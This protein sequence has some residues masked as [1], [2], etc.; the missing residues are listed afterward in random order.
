MEE[1]GSCRA[2]CAKVRQESHPTE[3]DPTHE[4]CE[5]RLHKKTEDRIT[6]VGPILGSVSLLGPTHT[7]KSRKE[8]F[9]LV[10]LNVAV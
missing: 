3:Q 8:K 7:T 9:S 1:R 10:N 2:L 4:T 6:F 5:A